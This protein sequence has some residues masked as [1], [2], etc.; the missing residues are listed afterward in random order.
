[1]F[2]HR[3]FCTW[4][5]VPVLIFLA[6][7]ACIKQGSSIVVCSICSSVFVHPRFFVQGVPVLI[8]QATTACI[9]Q[10]SSIA[11]WSICFATSCRSRRLYQAGLLAFLLLGELL[12][13]RWSLPRQSV[14]KR[15]VEVLQVSSCNRLHETGQASPQSG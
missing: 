1:M 11:V 2:V 9:R 4:G 3:R 6:T 5:G 10:G 15:A 12:I 14:G 13:V 7:T 8:F